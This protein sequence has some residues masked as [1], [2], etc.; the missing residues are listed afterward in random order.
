MKSLTK[1]QRQILALMLMHGTTRFFGGTRLF[2]YTNAYEDGFTITAYQDPELFLERRGLIERVERNAS[3]RW[4]KLTASG[5]AAAC[6]VSR[7][8]LL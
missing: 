3:G 5:H 7:F 1:R 2:K 6:R 4:Y 8:G